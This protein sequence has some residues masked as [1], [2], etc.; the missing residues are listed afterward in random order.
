MRKLSV[1]L[2]FALAPI[3]GKAAP[4]KLVN[5]AAPAINCIFTTASPCTIRVSDTWAD[6]PMSG[7]GTGR[8]QSRTFKGLAGSPADGLFAYEYRLNLTDAVGAANIACVD[9]M[10]ISFGPVVSTLDYDSDHKPDQVFVVT[11]G[12]VG[13]IGLASAVQTADTIRFKFS[14]P[15]CEGGAPGKGDTS[16]FWGLV[17]KSPAKDVTAILHETGGA[18]HVVKARSPM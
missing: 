15:V 1:A 2:L 13:T 8:L 14:K 18:T 17:A 7:G 5:V 3:V 16:F 9:W 4:L 11:S 10:S 6:V 12:A